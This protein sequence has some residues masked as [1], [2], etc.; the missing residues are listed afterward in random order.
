MATFASAIARAVGAALRK[1]SKAST[2]CRPIKAMHATACAHGA[3]QCGC[4]AL[5]CGG[6]D[7]PM[8]SDL[9]RVATTLGCKWL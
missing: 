8:D 5:R 1:S 9:E 7:K 3:R 2:R 6:M 4:Y